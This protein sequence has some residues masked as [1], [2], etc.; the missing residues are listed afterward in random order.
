MKYCKSNILMITYQVRTIYVNEQKLNI[1][2]LVL[3]FQYIGITN[4]FSLNN[5]K[6]TSV[7]RFGLNRT[8]PFGLEKSSTEWFEILWFGLNR[9]QFG[10]FGLTRFGLV[11]LRTPGENVKRNFQIT[12]KCVFEI[13]FH[14][15]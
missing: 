3:E 13:N 11:F 4:I 7:S 10:W 8:E 6:N 9:F 2:G 15:K 14:Q 5:Y 1:S 12:N